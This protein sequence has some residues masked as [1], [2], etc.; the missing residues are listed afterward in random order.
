MWF[1]YDNDLARLL[2][3]DRM[4]D[5]LRANG[6]LCRA[7]DRMA[8]LRRPVAGRSSFAWPSV[9]QFVGRLLT[10]STN[11]LGPAAGVSR[12]DPGCAG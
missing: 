10:P 2:V 11:R 6:R 3:R 9:R 8:A 12:C 1:M 5:A 4:E 7:D